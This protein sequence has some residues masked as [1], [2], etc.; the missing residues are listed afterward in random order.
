MMFSAA[1]INE[2]KKDV[3]A[4]YPN[5]ACGVIAGQRYIPCANTHETP[6]MQFRIDGKERMAVERQ[7]GRVEA[8]LHSHPYDL[9]KSRQFIDDQ[10]SPAW[11]SVPDQAGFIADNVPWGIV[12]SDGVGISE[13]T[14]LDEDTI[15]PFAGRQFAWFVADCFTC[16]RDWH[17]LNT[18]IVLPNFTREWGF[19]KKGINTIEDNLHRTNG[20]RYPTSKAQ[21]GD[22]AVLRIAGSPIVNHLGVITGS[23][24]FL[25]QWAGTFYAHF[26]PWNVYAVKAAYVLRFS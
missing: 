20:V 25:H 15:A 5:E 7:Y 13:V 12:A 24:E 19:W 2:F 11:P 17:R 14:W 6:T 26:S 22:V 10:F 18:K 23:N 3:L 4:K 21:V 8:I 9:M 16:V 1:V